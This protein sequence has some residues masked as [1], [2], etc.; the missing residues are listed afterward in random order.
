M[1][2]QSER[3]FYDKEIQPI[4]SMTKIKIIEAAIELFSMK[5]FSGSSIR[6]I[7]KEVGIKESSLYKHFANK[8]EILEVIFLNFRRETAKLLPPMEYIDQIIE[9]MS[10]HE[11]LERG[12]QNFLQHIDDSINQKVWRIM[13]IELFQHPMAQDIYMNEIMKRTVD[14]LTIVFAG[15]QQRGK[16]KPCDPRLLATEYQSAS[17][18]LILEYNLLKATGKSTELMEQS[19][20]DHV[21]FFSAMA[22]K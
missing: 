10:F 12:I 1:K 14:C 18:T 9:S 3:V 17:I 21:S 5:G 22:S 16:I 2:A 8:H 20:K 6:D 15:M 4:A 13:Y 11:F 19:I 7:T